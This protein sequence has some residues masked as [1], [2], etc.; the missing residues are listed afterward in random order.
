[1]N[2]IVIVRVGGMAYEGWKS[3]RITRGVSRCAGDFEVSLTERWAGRDSPWIIT[4]GAGCSVQIGGE[5]V[6]TGYVDSY[7]PSFSRDDHTVTVA[8]RSRTCDVVDCSAIC[9]NSQILAGTLQ[10]IAARLC[11]PFGVA[12]SMTEGDDFI[13]PD[14]T[15]NQGETCFEIIER[16]SRVRG[17]L[18]CDDAGG[19]LVLA[20]AGAG[21]GAGAIRQG[22]NILSASGCLS[23]AER[24][25]DYTIKFQDAQWGDTAGGSAAGVLATVGDP[26]VSRYRPKILIAEA[27]QGGTDLAARRGKWEAARRAGQGTRARISVQGWRDGAGQLWR[28]NSIASVSSPWLGI[29]ADLLIADVTYRLDAQGSVTEMVLGPK[30]AYEPEPSGFGGKWTDVQASVGRVEESR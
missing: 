5:T 19:N 24:F 8:G 27:G 20:R 30:A 2:N 13:F 16:L 15:I 22:G 28:P 4:E 14:T 7:Q 21:G 17:F 3:V 23:I 29:S 10:S 12:V 9:P 1:M 26:G 25:S 18:V 11:A 6:I